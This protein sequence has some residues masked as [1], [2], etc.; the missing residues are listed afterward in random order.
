MLICSDAFWR[1]VN[2]VSSSQLIMV[3]TIF[4]R[5]LFQ[6]VPQRALSRCG[7]AVCGD[8]VGWFHEAARKKY[9]AMPRTL[10]FPLEH[11]CSLV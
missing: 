8:A 2:G 5:L 11:P 6:A 1:H 3:M 4:V 9:V 7:R 10:G